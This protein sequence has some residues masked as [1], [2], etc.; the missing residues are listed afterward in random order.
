MVRSVMFRRSDRH[1]TKSIGRGSRRY[2]ED[3][4]D[5]WVCSQVK[6]FLAEQ[7]Y[8]YSITDAADL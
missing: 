8:A 1:W 2:R 4:E 5:P 6:R 7:G 3:R